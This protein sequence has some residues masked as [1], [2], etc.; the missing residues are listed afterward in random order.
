MKF[1][2]EF[3][4]RFLERISGEAYG[5][6]PKAIFVVIGVK[7]VQITDQIFRRIPELI[8]TAIAEAIPS[9]FIEIHAGISLG[10]KE[11]IKLHQ[12]APFSKIKHAVF[13]YTLN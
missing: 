6:T 4:S 12:N 2:Q 8:L 1:M 13:S 3:S 5:C 7:S 11:Q 10:I 9:F